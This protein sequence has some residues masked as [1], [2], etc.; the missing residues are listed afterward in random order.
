M[1][2]ILGA[3]PLQ[4]VFPIAAI[5]DLRVAFI[6]ARRRSCE[7]QC[8]P[9]LSE[10]RRGGG[11]CR[12][13]LRSPDVASSNVTKCG[14]VLTAGARGYF[15]SRYRY[16]CTAHKFRCGTRALDL[17]L[18]PLCSKLCSLPLAP[19]G[20]EVVA[21]PFLL[22]L[23]HVLPIVS[24]VKLAATCSHVRCVVVDGR[25]SV[26]SPSIVDVHSAWE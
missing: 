16:T 1:L 4:T 26:T 23:L 6:L 14:Q 17:A 8:E 22:P 24:V 2:H 9:R 18:G 7:P 13:C 15:E 5:S 20:G 10:P 12:S 21:S 11:S 19:W 3:P 25:P